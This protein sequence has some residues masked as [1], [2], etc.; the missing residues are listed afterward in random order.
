MREDDRVLQTLLELDRDRRPRAPPPFGE[1]LRLLADELTQMFRLE[2]GLPVRSCEQPADRARDGADAWPARR[3]LPA[4]FEQPR[5]QL[6]AAGRVFLGDLD[7]R[8]DRTASHPAAAVIPGPA[9]LLDPLPQDRGHGAILS[10][11]RHPALSR[12]W[13]R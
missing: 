13:M 5:Q 6:L 7:E 10:E 3:Q 4:G 8:L 1:G 2:L 11:G 9:Q 12:Q